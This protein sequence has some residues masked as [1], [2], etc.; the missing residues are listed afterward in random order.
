MA[1]ERLKLA[2]T[3]RGAGITPAVLHAQYRPGGRGAFVP[4]GLAIAPVNI[5]VLA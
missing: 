1:N 3:C 5:A 2:K 4:P